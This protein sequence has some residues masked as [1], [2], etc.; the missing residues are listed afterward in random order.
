M[1][2]LAG[3]DIPLLSYGTK[4]KQDRM[5]NLITEKPLIAYN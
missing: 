2:Q 4:L 1:D 5:V 3:L